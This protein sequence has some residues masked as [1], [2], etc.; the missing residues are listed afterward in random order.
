MWG[1]DL[2][3]ILA[4]PKRALDYESVV[5]KCV[6]TVQP[7]VSY[8]VTLPLICTKKVIS[9]DTLG[10]GSKSLLCR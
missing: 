9:M 10:T 5:T 2:W 6:F 1:R 3:K 4:P 7:A 8:N